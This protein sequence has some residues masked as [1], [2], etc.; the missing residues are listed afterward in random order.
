MTITVDDPFGMAGKSP[1]LVAP[2]VRR[3][4]AI[5]TSRVR[6]ALILGIGCLLFCLLPVMGFDATLIWVVW[7]VAALFVPFFVFAACCERRILR[8]QQSRLAECER[9]IEKGQTPT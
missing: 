5:Q 3:N 2:A 6:D 1:R 4:I 7:P 9:L 8:F